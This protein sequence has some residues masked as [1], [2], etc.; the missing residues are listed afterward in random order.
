MASSACAFPHLMRAPRRHPG[1]S[2]SLT[3]L[4]PSCE[5]RIRTFAAERRRMAT[6][7]S[8]AEP[9]R[10]ARS[11]KGG[12]GEPPRAPGRGLLRVFFSSPLDPGRFHFASRAPP[13]PGRS[14]F[15]SSPLVLVI[16]VTFT[17]RRP[18]KVAGSSSAPRAV[19]LKDGTDPM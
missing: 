10:T 7:A 1:N 17:P 3:L 8:C 9:R 11:A 16:F 13:G 12:T 14:C 6:R 4:R 15:V 2:H 5:V 19:F 18:A